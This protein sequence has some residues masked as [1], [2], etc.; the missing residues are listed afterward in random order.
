MHCSN[1][2]NQNSVAMV[3]SLFVYSSLRLGFWEV[4]GFGIYG[5]Y[6]SDWEAIGGFNTGEYKF[7]WGGEDWAS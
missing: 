3:L 6:R 7:N 5:M 1:L 4:Q 2:F